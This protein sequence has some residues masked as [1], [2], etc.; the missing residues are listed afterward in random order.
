MVIKNVWAY[1]F[2]VISFFPFS[3][4]TEGKSKRKYEKYCL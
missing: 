1:L 4:S 2:Y 3:E